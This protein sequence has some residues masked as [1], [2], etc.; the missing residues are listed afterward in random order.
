MRRYGMNLQIISIHLRSVL[1]SRI[2]MPRDIDINLDLYLI[3][4]F[5]MALFVI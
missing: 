1:T 3:Y 4:Y 2:Y 5:I